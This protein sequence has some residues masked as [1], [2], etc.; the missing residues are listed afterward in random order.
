[1]NYFV[2]ERDASGTLLSNKKCSPCIST[3]YPGP[4]GRIVN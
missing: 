1:L 4:S 2:Q 3:A